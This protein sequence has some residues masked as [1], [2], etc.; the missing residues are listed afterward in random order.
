M[1]DLTLAVSESAL[2][3]VFGDLVEI[4]Q[5]DVSKSTSG[6]PKFA[7]HVKAHLERG[8]F[9]LVPPDP[10]NPFYT[11]GFF[12]LDDVVIAWD[13]LDLTVTLHIPGVSTPSF[14]LVPN[15][16]TGGCWVEIPS[17]TFF[18]FDVSVTVPIDNIVRSRIDLGA[19]P[20]A[21]H[22]WDAGNNTWVWKIV[23][24]IVWTNVQPLDIA[25][26]VGD[27]I[28]GIV[29]QIVND[30]LS[31]LP[32][33]AID[34]VDAIVHGIASFIRTLLSLPTD[35]VAWL[36]NLLRISLDPFSLIIQILVDHFQNDLALYTINDPLEVLKAE[37]TPVILPPV[38]IPVSNLDLSVAAVE[39]VI[40]VTS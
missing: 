19:A 21:H 17:V 10:G 39:F 29:T 40:G 14:C 26:T 7:V 25:D 18:D 27:L 16:I 32:G 12:K 37:T 20:L 31:F 2:E 22:V 11:G 9:S 38:T 34:I 33:W 36:D 4:F 6:N 35:L 24:E 3:R 28:D 15:P 5:F 13:N 23:P 30:A 8:S 1:N